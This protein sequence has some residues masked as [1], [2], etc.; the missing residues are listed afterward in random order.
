MWSKVLKLNN[1]V[2]KSAKWAKWYHPPLGV[3]LRF[4]EDSACQEVSPALSVYKALQ[5]WLLLLLIT[6][7]Q[8]ECSMLRLCRCIKFFYVI[9]WPSDPALISDIRENSLAQG[10]TMCDSWS[11]KLYPHAAL[12]LASQGPA[13]FSG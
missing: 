7:C 11:Q 6:T 9:S 13:V 3:M 2:C 12:A 8:A 4:R 10:H 1:P 5:N